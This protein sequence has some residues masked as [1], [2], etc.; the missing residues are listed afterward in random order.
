MP[1]IDHYRSRLRID[2]HA[3][4]DEIEVQA[5]YQDEIS[6]ELAAANSRMLLAKDVLART[7][8]RVYADLKS[9]KVSDTAANLQV[10]R[11]ADRIRDW[12]DWMDARQEHEEWLGLY[13]AW[14]R[15]GYSIKTAA[16][17]YVAQYFS[18]GTSV[19]GNRH[20]VSV[21][22]LKASMRASA[23]TLRE[24]RAGGNE[25]PQPRRR[26]NG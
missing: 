5:Q 23:R 12:Q 4:D 9:D 13:D 8:A 21:D 26:I 7:E 11:S 10:K 1:T 16:D 18:V 24:V 15:R 3:L 6:R 20:E 19:S 14:Q 17:L 2:K 22:S 25:T